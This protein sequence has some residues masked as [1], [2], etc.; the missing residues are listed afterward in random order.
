MQ[1]ICQNTTRMNRQTFVRLC[2]RLEG[3]GI[4]RLTKNMLVD[5]QVAITLHILAH[6]QKQRTIKY[7]FEL[8]NSL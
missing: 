4:V 8:G 1:L 3:T 2:S 6:H 7:N 5:E